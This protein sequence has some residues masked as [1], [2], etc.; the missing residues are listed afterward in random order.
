MALPVR[1]RGRA[2]PV[3]DHAPPRPKTGGTVVSCVMAHA[4]GGLRRLYLLTQHGRSAFF[5]PEESG[6]RGVWPGVA[7]RGMGTQAIG[8]DAALEGG[9]SVRHVVRPRLAAWRA[10]S[11]GLVPAWCTLGA[12]ST[13][14]TSRPSAWTSAA[15][16]IGWSYGTRPWRWTLG[17]P[18][19]QGIV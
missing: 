12:G 7:G 15:P 8:G 10:P 2:W 13:G 19:A 4:T 14:L 16:T 1:M 5:D 17:R 18:A 11:C 3:M 9:G 6:P